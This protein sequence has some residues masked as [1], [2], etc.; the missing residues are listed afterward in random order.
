MCSALNK[1]CVGNLSQDLN[2]GNVLCSPGGN[3][4]WMFDAL[5]DWEGAVVGRANDAR[6][7]STK[8]ISCP[9]EEGVASR[10]CILG[11]V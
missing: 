11:R 1:S 8:T 3:G 9:G 7:A 6:R 5:I 4:R 10:D 2:D